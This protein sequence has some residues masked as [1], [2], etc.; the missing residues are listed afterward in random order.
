MLCSGSIAAG[1][2]TVWAQKVTVYHPVDLAT[3]FS[4]NFLLNADL[5]SD[6]FRYCRPSSGKIQMLFNCSCPAAMF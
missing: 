6:W 4:V 5:D 2:A 3:S 1:V